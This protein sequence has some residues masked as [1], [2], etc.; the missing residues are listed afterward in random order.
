MLVLADE[1]AQAG[2]VAGPLRAFADAGGEERR[3]EMPEERRLKP[4]QF[5]G[6]EGQP[7]PERRLIRRAEEQLVGRD[8]QR[9]EEAVGQGRAPRR[10]EFGGQVHCIPYSPNREQ[11][12][13]YIP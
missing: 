13:A 5:S 9:V 4:I 3:A 11:A 12:F 2:L 7:E 1:A 10:A 8:G 6:V